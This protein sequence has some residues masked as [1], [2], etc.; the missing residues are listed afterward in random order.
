MS[1]IISSCFLFAGLFHVS[2]NKILNF[3]YPW[4]PKYILVLKW[5]FI[6]YG[7]YETSC[8][9]YIPEPLAREYKTHNEFHKYRMKWKFISDSF[10]HMIILKKYMYQYFMK[11]VCPR[12]NRPE[13]SCST[14]RHNAP[15]YDVTSKGARNCSK[16]CYVTCVILENLWNF[17]MKGKIMW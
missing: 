12:E 6:S 10:Y 9:F 2:Q 7:I 15:S 4:I 14:R 16:K 8:V 17:F 13:A 11:K 3:K 1:C 5:I